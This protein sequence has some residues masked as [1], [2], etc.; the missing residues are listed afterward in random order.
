MMDAH[1][2]LQ[3]YLEQKKVKLDGNIYYKTQTEFAYSSNKIEGSKLTENQTR[4]IFD[5]NFFS[6]DAPVD[7]I[8]ETQ[9][10]FTAFDYIIDHAREPLSENHLRKLHAILK[11]G[12]LQAKNLLHSVGA[13]KI[14]DN[15]IGELQTTCPAKDTPEAMFNLLHD[16]TNSEHIHK[17]QD[18]EDIVDFHAA[19]EAIH[20]FSDGNGRIGRLVMFKECLRNNIIP[21]I[22]TDEMRAFY[23]RGLQ[24]YR[25]EKG[26]LV[27]TC[28]TAQ[29]HFVEKSLPLAESYFDA[30]QKISF[31]TPKKE[32][33]NCKRKSDDLE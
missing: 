24:N 30:L 10:H 11:E 31:S 12:T 2:L 18:F 29:D 26:W 28:L 7:D 19:F 13:Y 23:I 22:I 14:Y 4:M 27:D 32:S 15:E 33:K 25:E 16:Y 17:K 8:L 9:N 1:D 21:F 6:G 5:R 20:P 3:V